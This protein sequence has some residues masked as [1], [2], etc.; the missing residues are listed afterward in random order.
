[1][2]SCDRFVRFPIYRISRIAVSLC[3]FSGLFVGLY[4]TARGKGKKLKADDLIAR[5][6]ICLGPA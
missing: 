3:L 5:R 2:K 6:R 1:M 4:V